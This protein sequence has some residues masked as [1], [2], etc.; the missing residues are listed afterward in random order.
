MFR[1]CVIPVTVL[2]A[3]GSASR[4]TENI[5]YHCAG[6]IPKTIAN[7]GQVVRVFD[8]P[9][10]TILE[11]SD[12]YFVPGSMC[13]YDRDGVRITESCT[14]RGAGL[15]EFLHA[16]DGTILL[17]TDFITVEEPVVYLSWLSN[18]WGHFLTEGTSRLWALFQCPELAKLTGIY[19]TRSPV[20]GNIRDFIRAL[21]LSI[22]SGR[23]R[24]TTPIK[25]RAL[26]LNLRSGR[27]RPTTPIKFRKIFIPAA[28]FSNRAQ[29]YCVHREAA[30]AVS[31]LL[32]RENVF[33]VSDQPV[34][35]SRSRLHSDRQIQNQNEL[36]SA[37]ARRGFLIVYPEEFTLSEQVVLFNRHRHFSGCWGSAFHSAIFSR[38]PDSIATHIICHSIPNVNYLMLDTILGN[39]ANYV[40][41]IF[42]VPGKEQ[43]WPHLYLSIDVEQTLRYY[44]GIF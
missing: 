30:A 6:H 33:Q 1:S 3:A 14:R 4:T 31:D 17:P 7:A 32:L 25:I 38:E 29:G 13:L 44:E 10:A 24:P 8:G 40:G 20:H 12:A 42:P 18:H 11:I 41:S 34:F 2:S 9:P 19:L 23:C 27:Y 28:S 36:E 5:K 39:D 35:L 37:L 26:G 22:R 21:G 15:T 16:G 43:V